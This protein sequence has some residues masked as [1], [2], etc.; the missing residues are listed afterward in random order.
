MVVEEVCF[1]KNGEWDDGVTEQR[2]VQTDHVPRGRR[3]FPLIVI[4]IKKP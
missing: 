1:G 4:M 3:N 2:M